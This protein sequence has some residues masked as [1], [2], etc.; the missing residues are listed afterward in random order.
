M[1]TLVRINYISEPLLDPLNLKVIMIGD[2]DVG[3]T[4]VLHTFIT[5]NSSLKIKTEDLETIEHS[6]ANGRTRSMSGTEVYRPM[7]WKQSIV[8]SQQKRIILEI[9]DTAG[10]ISVLLN[11][12]SEVIRTYYELENWIEKSVSRIAVWHHK[13]CQTV[14]AREGFFYPILTQILEFFFSCSL[15]KISETC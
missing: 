4:T 13:A 5:I 11:I 15:D 9:T 10:K 12:Q 1:A 14:I 6:A 8:A 3:K 7:R 2:I